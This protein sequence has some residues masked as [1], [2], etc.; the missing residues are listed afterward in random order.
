MDDFFWWIV[1]IGFAAQLV[2]GALGMAYGLT[3][4]SLLISIGLPPA[5]A[6]ATVHAA[7]VFTTAVSGTSH[8]FARN[9]DWKM[10]RTLAIAG[11]IGGAAGA[12]LLSSGIGEYLAPF[13]ALYL[14]ALGVLVIA[15][16][17]R[18]VQP[19]A[20]MRGLAP[21]GLVGGFLDAVG[22]G[23]WGPIVS[24]TLV[25]RGHAEPH[26]MLGTSAASEFFVTVMITVTFAGHFGLE[27]FGMAALALVIGGV[28]AAPLAAVLVRIIPRKPLMIA[29]GLLIV[30]LGGFGIYRF[31]SALLVA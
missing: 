19:P 17:V 29:V 31:V 28:P 20:A 3:S 9:V 16:A 10:V 8:H 1:L 15:K 6:S 22:G 11:S 12:A 18:K 24:S 25:Y 21:L 27:S 23:G 5:Q 14:S 30:I 26:R 13:V 2:D 7:E 4:T